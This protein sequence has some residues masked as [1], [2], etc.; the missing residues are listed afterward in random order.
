MLGAPKKIP[1]CAMQRG[2]FE[3]IG[4]GARRLYDLLASSVLDNA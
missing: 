1:R 3:L 4:S 2:I